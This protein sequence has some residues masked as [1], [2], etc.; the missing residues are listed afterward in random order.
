MAASYSSSE[1]DLDQYCIEGGENIQ[2]YEFQ[3]KKRKTVECD[4]TLQTLEDTSSSDISSSEEEE[5]EVRQGNNNWCQCGKCQHTLLVRDKEFICC[6]ERAKTRIC[7]KACTA[8][9]II[10]NDYG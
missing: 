7:T 9:M 1:S 4:R 3:P 2:P 6:R 10:L 5:T 8:G